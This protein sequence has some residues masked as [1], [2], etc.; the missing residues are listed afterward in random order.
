VKIVVV[1]STAPPRTGGTE[2]MLDILT[3]GFAQAGHGVAVVT[4]MP[5]ACFSDDVPGRQLFVGLGVRQSLR[6]YRQADIVFHV[7]LVSRQL[8]AVAV[9]KRPL[10]I[11][12]H[13]WIRRSSG[14]R[15]IRDRLKLMTLRFADDVICVSSAL[16]ADVPRRARII[17]NCY[18]DDVFTERPET[19]GSKSLLF[20]GRLVSDKGADLAIEAL[21]R[22][23]PRHP[24]L[25]LFIVGDGPEMASL[26]ERAVQLAVAEATHFVGPK[27]PAEVAA[28]MRAAAVVVIPSVWKE[29]FGLVA[30]EAQACGARVVSSDAGGLPEAVGPVGHLFRS[31]DIDALAAAIH[32]A[33]GRGELERGDAAR[34]REHLNNHRVVP[35]VQAYLAAF[36]N[37][38]SL[39]AGT[40]RRY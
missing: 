35:V 16:A 3:R 33:L 20:V 25:S 38:L 39:R 12:L 37:A 28:F 11:S 34:V 9:T 21:A 2:V 15:S 6:L 36:E 10:V 1:A 8:P 30:L 13:T 27:R 19:G 22:L 4:R 29:P 14:R 17:H 24:D 26:R 5:E 23:R 7:N 31:G 32:D 18:Q 40:S